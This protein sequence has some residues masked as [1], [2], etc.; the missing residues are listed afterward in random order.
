[1]FVT[2]NQIHAWVE[3]NSEAAR[4]VIVELVD[5]L[6]A[7]A[8][9][10]AKRRFPNADSIGQHGPDGYVLAQSGAPPFIPGGTSFWEVGTGRDAAAKAT[11]DYRDLTAATPANVRQASTFVFVTPRSGRHDWEYTWKDESQL[12]W[13]NDRRQ[14]GD[15]AGVDVI[16]ATQL[17]AWIR[18]FP[19]VAA[20]LAAQMGLAS[21]DVTSP[22]TRWA[23][24]QKASTPPLAPDVFLTGRSQATMAFREILGGKR[25]QLRL[26]TRTPREFVPF[27][28]AA[29]ASLEPEKRR[30]YEGRCLLLRTPEAWSLVTTLREPHVFIAAFDLD[31]EDGNVLVQEALSSGHSAIFAGRPGGDPDSRTALP[32]PRPQELRD[33]LIKCGFA[34]PRAKELAQKSAGQP[35]V[36]VK[37]VTGVPLRPSWADAKE[38]DAIARAM[39]AG[40]WSAGVPKDLAIVS[41]I[42]YD[43][44]WE[45][46]I[47][48]ALQ[49]ED[50]PI[51][52]RANK[53]KVSSRYEA[54]QHLGPHIHDADL[55]RFRHAALEVLREPDPQLELPKNERF[56]ANVLGK[57][58]QYSPLLR[59]GIAETLALLGSHPKALSACTPGRA[60]GTAH[61]IVRELLTDADHVLWASLNPIEPLLAEA[62]PDAFLSAL[63][64]ALRRTPSPFDAVFAEEGNGFA[65]RTYMTGVLW[66]LES[67]AWDPVHLHR[68]ALV[69]AELAAHDPGGQWGNRPS[70]SLTTIFLP[71][72]PQT[73]AN[74]DQRAAAVRA[75]VG[76]FP[77]QG[78]ALLE[79]LLP[80]VHSVSSGTHQ[81]TWRET[82]PLDYKEGV[83]HDEYARQTDTYA[84]I[85]IEAASVNHARLPRLIEKMH[86]LPA[87]AFD[88]LLKVIEGPTIRA[89][90]EEERLPIWEALITAVNH[91]TR[92]PDAAWSLKG[93]DLARLAAAATALAPVDPSLKH[94]WLFGGKDYELH[95]EGDSYAEHERKMLERKSAALR[96]IIS[97]SGLPSVRDFVESV[98]AP[99]EVGLALGQMD[100]PGAD[101]YV[102][103]GLLFDESRAVQSAARAFVR[104]RWHSHRWPWVDQLD[105]KS[106]KHEQKLALYCALPF[107]KDT[108]ER[109]ERNLDDQGADYWKTCDVRPW[110]KEEGLSEAT[111]K[112]IAHSRGVGALECLSRLEH[113][114]IPYDRN[115]A[116]RALHAAL[117]SS[118]LSKLDHYHTIE[119]I[120]KV[121]EDP[122][123]SPEDIARIEFAYL[124][125]LDGLS[126]KKA[127]PK[128]LEHRLATD[129]DFFCEAV[130]LTFKPKRRSENGEDTPLT[131][132]ELSMSK[133]C[134]QLLRHW[135]IPPGTQKDGVFDPA[136]FTNWLDR[137]K[138]GLTKLDRLEVGLMVLGE[139]L[140]HTPVDPD[141]FWIQRSAAQ[142][143]NDRDAEPMRRGFTVRLYN[144]RGIHGF[145][146]GKAEMDSATRYTQQ[147]EATTNAG[148][149]RLGAAMR[150]LGKS[151]ERESE[152]FGSGH[153]FYDDE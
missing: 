72:L 139:V 25:S 95:E 12:A 57:T 102:L 36:V 54:W 78:M 29:L 66:A 153:P 108:W 98:E 52:Q 136:A 1:M 107:Q 94:R 86:D 148:Y 133:A 82:I 141:G 33:E 116:I 63:E 89:L 127:R 38:A 140:A 8:A 26:D 62:A 120:E 28:A 131:E 60:E 93:D 11:N 27:T 49:L 146:R 97:R 61:L 110:A 34:E 73:C 81:P 15:W 22:V 117:T 19:A 149:P 96:E 74:V 106:W 122:N 71:W 147:A 67:L 123:L 13:L 118:D 150:E 76:D 144:S 103:P 2:E 126:A 84:R 23:T 55:E 114:K 135:K 119:L 65:G 132:R 134:H 130:G 137:A 40:A 41:A 39:L 85:L 21:A 121:Q 7:A 91:H 99:H 79:S 30:E 35:A 50:S 18:M 112:L 113:D 14:R 53:W 143:L 104:G 88:A 16:D 151:Y 92:F 3:Q 105:S 10:H 24:I 111:E 124:P 17:V 5:R 142:A 125:L 75:L 43:K 42:G 101:A 6:V 69:L 145:S 80:S 68:V 64:V 32:N 31:D 46:Q 9:P 83:T 4:G 51:T 100:I 152:L 115:L 37:L 44:E 20:W 48:R 58:L 47:K 87:S 128:T 56:M 59:A 45:A 138:P 109:A 129:P 90:E 70:N 77:D